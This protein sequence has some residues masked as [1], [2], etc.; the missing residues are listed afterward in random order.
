LL[1]RLLLLF[2]II[3]FVELA[4]LIEVGRR[5][6]T[7]WTL[8]L[9]VVTGIVGGLL[10]RSEGLAVWHGLRTEVNAG[11]VP[12]THLVDGV[13]IL[14]GGLLLLTPGILTDA[15]GF[16]ALI[17]PSRAALR[18][19]LMRKLAHWIQSGSFTILG[20]KTRVR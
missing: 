14:A 2:T 10:A 17:G 9:I 5:I 6:G 18:N 8:V 15:V 12:A 20:P 19:W 4:L 3:P 1:L 16:A 7:G 11:N 13:L